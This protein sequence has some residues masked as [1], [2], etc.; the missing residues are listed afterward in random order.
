MH[1][2]QLPGR[3]EV[4]DLCGVWLLSIS[5]IPGSPKSTVSVFK[6]QGAEGTQ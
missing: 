5:E 1:L 3:A 6:S 2:K 4:V